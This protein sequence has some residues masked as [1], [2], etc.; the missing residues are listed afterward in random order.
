[1]VK[2]EVN[3]IGVDYDYFDFNG[4]NY[5]KIIGRDECGKR[6]CVVDEIKSYF[7]AVL[8]EGIGE[9]KANEIAE[10]IG[11]IKIKSEVRESIVEKVSV[12]NKKFLGKEVKAL[13]IFVTNHKDMHA[14]ADEI[15]FE[16]VE[17]RREYDISLITKYISEKD[18]VPLT[19]K[20]IKG[21]LIEEG[22]LGGIN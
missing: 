1:M 2:K 19:W 7:W 5:V 18:F 21:E 13:K 17:A 20:K 3:F 22:E 12:E 9:K 10:K 4:R 14:V 8:K 16:E 11:R 15:G 6:V